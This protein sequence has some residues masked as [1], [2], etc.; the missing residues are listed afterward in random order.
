[1]DCLDNLIYNGYEE[2]TVA[3]DGEW[4]KHGTEGVGPNE[5]LIVYETF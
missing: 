3:H 1:M 5:C 4:V 2:G